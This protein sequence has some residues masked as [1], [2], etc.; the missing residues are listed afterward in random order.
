MLNINYWSLFI[1]IPCLVVFIFLFL[2][3]RKF[4]PLFVLL[5]AIAFP[6]ITVIGLSTNYSTGIRTEDI[7]I[8]GYCIVLLIERF[9]YVKDFFKTTLFKV[10]IFYILLLSISLITGLVK[11]NEYSILGGVLS[12]VRRIEY[13]CFVFVGYDFY[14]QNKKYF[15]DIIKWS[16]SIIILVNFFIGIYQYTNICGAFT[17]GSYRNI[18]MAAGFFNGPY[19]LGAFCNLVVAIFFY[20]LVKNKKY[21]F[22]NIATIVIS[23]IL[24]LLTK[25][26]ISLISLIV[27]LSL[28]VI[29]LS[30]KKFK[31]ITLIVVPLIIALVVVIIKSNT[32]PVLNRFSTISFTNL[33]DSLFYYL[34]NASYDEYIKLV[35][36]NVSLEDYVIQTGDK[37]FNVRIFKWLSAVDLFKEYPLFG[38]GF[39]ATG[40]LDGSYVK[41][42]TETGVIGLSVFIFMFAIALFGHKNKKN[43]F[44]QSIVFLF[45][46]IA[47]SAIL[48]DTFEASKIMEPLWFFIGICWS[49]SQNDLESSLNE[50]G[51]SMENSNSAVSN[52]DLILENKK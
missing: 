18:G 20:D 34:E 4:L 29:M 15:F 51:V 11:E 49:H 52:E 37:S 30:S 10:F 38:Y 21:N 33:K 22:L 46:T 12:Y 39:S 25:S 1:L 7:L 3:N 43:T 8:L 32:I 16:L 50:T 31:I 27:V 45:L 35:K 5:V 19:E 23:I 2:K 47:V 6:K 41:M 13:F 26:R 44:C 9:K 14:V 40:T 36:D 17:Q 28:I 42:L 24:I 48:I